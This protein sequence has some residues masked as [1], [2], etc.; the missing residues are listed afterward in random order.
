MQPA[1]CQVARSVLLP[2]PLIVLV[3]LRCRLHCP[4][5]GEHPA[6]QTAHTAP[7]LIHL[8]HRTATISAAATTNPLCTTITHHCPGLRC[9][10]R[11]C[12]SSNVHPV[13]VCLPDPAA[14]TNLSLPSRYH[15]SGVGRNPAPL[16]PS[17]RPPQRR[18][19]RP[20]AVPQA[21][22]RQRPSTI[23]KTLGLFSRAEKRAFFLPSPTQRWGGKE[24]LGHCAGVFSRPRL[25]ITFN[26]DQQGTS[27]CPD[28]FLLL[29]L[30]QSI[31]SNS[32]CELR[33]H[34]HASSLLVFA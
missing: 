11:G 19:L 30:G 6:T 25:V 21:H 32:P 23:S 31:R 17:A 22:C 20:L 8:F 1:P 3:L 5:R 18:R 34:I 12:P 7:L 14:S 26:F 15:V 2:P 28:R 4:A 16:L 24:R 13:V 33:S 29:D 9:R 27:F 10:C